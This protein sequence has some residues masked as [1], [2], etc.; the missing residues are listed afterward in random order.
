MSKVLSLIYSVKYWFHT[1]FEACFRIEIEMK[2][3]KRIGLNCLYAKY[4]VSQVV[5]C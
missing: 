2:N 5:S 4:V 1:H 3:W